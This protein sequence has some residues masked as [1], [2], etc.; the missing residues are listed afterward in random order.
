MVGRRE[1]INTAQLIFAHKIH[2]L[3]VLPVNEPVAFAV[4]EKDGNVTVIEGIDGTHLS[5][6]E[7]ASFD[8]YFHCFQCSLLSD[9]QSTF[10]CLL[11]YETA[12]IGEGT[13]RN[14]K[15]RL[16]SIKDLYAAGSAF[17]FS[18][19]TKEAV[20]TEYC[21]CKCDDSFDIFCFFIPE[22]TVFAAG[23]A[24]VSLIE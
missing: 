16:F 6:I 20:L 18:V 21:L 4:H 1:Y 10:E 8:A 22:G 5:V 23:Q 19:K 13:V 12:K 17:R 14:N 2:I 11:V 3:A 15:I 24:E 9:P 7:S